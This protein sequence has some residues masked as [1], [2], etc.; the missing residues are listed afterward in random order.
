MQP[1]DEGEGA[2]CLERRRQHQH[3]RL[4]AFARRPERGRA[5]GSVG[6]N[7]GRA[8]GARH[9][10]GGGADRIGGGG[11]QRAM[12]GIDNALVHRV[13]FRHLGNIVHH[14]DGFERIFS[15]RALRREHDRI[16]AVIDGVGDVGHLGAG[17]YRRGDH[18]FQHLRR[19][20]DRLARLARPGND[21]LLDRRDF[22]YRHF[23]AKIATGNHDRIG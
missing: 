8:D 3:R 17:R 14:R 6:H 22:L 18:A 12:L 5:R 23:D 10:G 20:D 15:R 2:R 19:D 9:L 11:F 7:A 13:L 4:A 16:G 1:P 21:L